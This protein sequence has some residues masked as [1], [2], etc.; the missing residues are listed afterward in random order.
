MKISAMDDQTLVLE[1]QKVIKYWTDDEIKLKR[2]DRATM[3]T[4]SARGWVHPPETGSQARML[5]C[6]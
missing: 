3:A 4:C 1:G 5:L 2:G 6:Y